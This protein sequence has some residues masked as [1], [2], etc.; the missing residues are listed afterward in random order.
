MLYPFPRS[1]STA[2]REISRRPAAAAGRA[3]RDI[4]EGVTMNAEPRTVA[5]SPK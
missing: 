1:V 2:V 3:D 5:A 4:R